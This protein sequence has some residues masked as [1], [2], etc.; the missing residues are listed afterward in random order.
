VQ[1]VAQTFALCLGR[2]D[3]EQE[4]DRVAVALLARMPCLAP[5][6][7]VP[8]ALLAKTLDDVDPQLRADGLRR[9]GH[10]RD[11][12]ALE[13]LADLAAEGEGPAAGG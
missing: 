1:S 6:E 9:L 8:R 13:E 3:R 10:R 12:R 11:R 4:V 7:P 2:L 5:G